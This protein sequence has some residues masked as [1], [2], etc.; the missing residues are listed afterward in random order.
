MPLPWSCRTPMW[1]D[2]PRGQRLC[3]ACGIRWQKYGVCCAEC[4]YVPR[5]N[6]NLAGSCPRCEAEL[7]PAVTTRRREMG[8]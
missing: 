7:P 3:N 6:E 2:G 1:R 8:K 5:K 4:T